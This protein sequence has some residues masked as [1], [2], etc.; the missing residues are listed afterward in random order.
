MYVSASAPVDCRQ[1]TY[2]DP[3]YRPP[4]SSA[5][6]EGSYEFTVPAAP[7]IS[8]SGDHVVPVSVEFE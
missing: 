4:E 8:R 3:L 6:T 1:A 2:T 7:S 5:A